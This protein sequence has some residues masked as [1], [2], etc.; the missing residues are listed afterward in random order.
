MEAKIKKS[1]VR[2]GNRFSIYAS[3]R[4]NV[5]RTSEGVKFIDPTTGRKR[6]LKMWRDGY[7]CFV[8]TGSSFY[9]LSK[10]TEKSDVYVVIDEYV[11][12]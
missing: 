2:K 7:M 12:M 1:I 10:T 9:K 6:T 4:A 11:E 5:T 3:D 8:K